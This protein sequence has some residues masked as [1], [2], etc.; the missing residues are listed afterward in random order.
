MFYKSKMNYLNVYIH[1]YFLYIYNLV[2]DLFFGFLV[3]KAKK[4]SIACMQRKT[5]EKQKKESRHGER[6]SW[7]SMSQNEWLLRFVWWVHRQGS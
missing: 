6:W 5:D 7:K 2:Q 1:F 4:A 3:S